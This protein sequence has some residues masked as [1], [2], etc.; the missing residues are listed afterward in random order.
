MAE[1]T[2]TIEPVRH[3][4]EVAVPAAEAFR[5]FVDQID[6]WWPL[7]VHS[8]GGERATGCFFEGR[9]GGRIY[10]AHHDGSLHLWGTVTEWQPPERVVF[11]WHPGREA[12]S[13]QEV[14][15]RFI[16]RDGR[17]V[18]EL[19]HRGWESL[20]TQ[21]AEIRERYHSG[22]PG[23]LVHYESRCARRGAPSGPVT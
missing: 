2:P 15:L 7:A 4:V 20:G 23:V 13:A 10:E 3:S 11:S 14:E 17:T 5:I 6:S 9:L 8:V 19:E 22:W 18:V 1:S 12:D 16:D 21:A